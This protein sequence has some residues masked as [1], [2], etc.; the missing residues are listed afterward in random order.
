MY[1]SI[2]RTSMF[3]AIRGRPEFQKYIPLYRALYGRP[4]RIFLDRGDSSCE[5]MVNS[6]CRGFG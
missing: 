2:D 4:A 3:T 1:N 6:R 5:E